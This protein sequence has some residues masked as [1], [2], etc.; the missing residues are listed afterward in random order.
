MPVFAVIV[1]SSPAGKRQRRCA[2]VL[3]AS[4]ISGMESTWKIFSFG[5]NSRQR[6][7]VA[8]S[9]SP[10]A[11]IPIRYNSMPWVASSVFTKVCSSSKYCAVVSRRA[12][13][14]S[15]SVKSTSTRAA[16]GVGGCASSWAPR[17]RASRIL[18]SPRRSARMTARAEAASVLCRRAT[19]VRG[20]CSL[21]ATLPKC[22][23]PKRMRWAASAWLA[24]KSMPARLPF[25]RRLPGSVGYFPRLML[26]DWSSSNIRSA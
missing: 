10:W 6:G 14:G 4:F 1:S 11:S 12:S 7:R 21:A 26:P 8:L 2:M 24:R 3:K 9:R 25:T 18:V 16:S 5:T 19:S 23:R 22:T 13:T 20:K 15:P 17:R